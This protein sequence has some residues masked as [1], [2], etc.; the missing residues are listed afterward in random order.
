MIENGKKLVFVKMHGCGNDYIFVDIAANDLPVCDAGELARRMSDRHFGI[1]GDG[2]VLICPPKDSANDARMRIY[3][4][5]GSEGRMCGNALRCVARYLFDT[6]PDMRKRGE[7]NIETLSG[8]RRA[9]HHALRGGDD[10][11]AS[12]GRAELTPKKIPVL[13]DGDDIIDRPIVIGDR[14]Y[15]I[16]CV[17]VGNPH[18]VIFCDDPDAELARA[19]AVIESAPIFPDRTNVEFVKVLGKNRLMMRVF[20]RGSGETL[21]CGTGAC[22]SSVAAVLCGLCNSAE[23]ITVEARGG[24]LF[25]G[26]CDDDITLRGA[27]EYAFFGSVVI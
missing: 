7:I 5:D 2:L 16:T 13:L 23:E 11:T 20:E 25:V 19:G 14:E 24:R 17:S 4:S 8:V 6:Y 27:A 22:A 12:M 10:I 9:A 18:C 3:N 15:R 21:A 26:I 1:G